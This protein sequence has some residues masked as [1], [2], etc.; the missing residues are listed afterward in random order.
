ME[1]PIILENCNSEPLMDS[2]IKKNW[3]ESSVFFF[4]ITVLCIFMFLLST[5]GALYVKKYT[6][7]P[8]VEVQPSSQF[9]PSYK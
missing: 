9:Q 5:C 7:K 2:D 6:G 3:A 4:Y 8:E 1:N